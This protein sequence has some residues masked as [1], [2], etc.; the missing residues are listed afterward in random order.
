MNLRRPWLGPTL[1]D[2]VKFLSIDYYLELRSLCDD[3]D[4]GTGEIFFDKHPIVFAKLVVK[5]LV[6]L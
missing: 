3:F 4:A 5:L 1:L 6:L 2:G